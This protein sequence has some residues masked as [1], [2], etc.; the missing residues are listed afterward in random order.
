MMVY[1]LRG[2]VVL[3]WIVGKLRKDGKF[4]FNFM[5]DW[6]YDGNFGFVEFDI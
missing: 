4:L 1:V 2:K 3:G 5:D 6:S